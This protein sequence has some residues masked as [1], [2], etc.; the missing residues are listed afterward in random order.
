MNASALFTT[1]HQITR[2]L[3]A[4]YPEINYHVTFSATLKEMYKDNSAMKAITSFQ[5]TEQSR[6]LVCQTVC[7]YLNRDPEIRATPWHGGDNIRVYIKMQ[8]G[9]GKWKQEGY[10]DILNEVIHA[11]ES[12]GYVDDKVA[13]LNYPFKA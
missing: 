9:N 13:E 6:E 4:E 7:E 8:T 2:A 11:V 3:K 5:Q 12:H 10:Y 1:A